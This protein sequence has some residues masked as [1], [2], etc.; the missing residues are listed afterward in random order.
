MPLGC[1]TIRTFTTRSHEAGPCASWGAS[2]LMLVESQCSEKMT[3][4]E[5]SGM[6][7]RDTTFR[8]RA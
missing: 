7:Q 6:Y 8:V 5:Q 4:Y 1:R 2:N 3:N